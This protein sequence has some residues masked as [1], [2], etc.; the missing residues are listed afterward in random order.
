[1]TPRQTFGDMWG[2]GARDWADLMEPHYYSL[3]EMVH[4]RLGVGDG[5]RLLD[6]GCGP[7]GAVFLASRRGAQ[8][9]G[10]DASP[11]SIE[12]ARERVP[13]GD[14]RVGDMESLPWTDG[15]F[16]TVTAFNSFQFARKPVGALTEA[17]RVLASGGKL[18]FAIFSQPQESQQTRIM[19]AIAALGPPTARRCRRR[20]AIY[21]R[22]PPSLR[23]LSQ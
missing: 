4:D 6:V 8:V 14:F 23:S 2:R 22:T 18:G 21:P 15:C 1:M 5:T 13:G 20:T 19:G 9:A 12:V 16:E 7:G 3:Y 11:G 10:L 17:R